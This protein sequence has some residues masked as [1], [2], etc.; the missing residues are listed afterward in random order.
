MMADK[1]VLFTTQYGEVGKER[2]PSAAGYLPYFEEVPNFYDFFYVPTP[3]FSLR[4]LREGIDYPIDILE[5]PTREEYRDALER[6]YDVVGFSFYTFAV[7][8][9]F[10]MAELARD[11]GV[12]EVWAGGYGVDTPAELEKHFD[13][14]FRGHGEDE[15]SRILTG[16]PSDGKKH[17]V[18][19]VRA[20]VAKREIPVG[21]LMTSM[22]CGAGCKF[23]HAT[24][25]MP[26][27]T[28]VPLEEIRRTLDEYANR[29]IVGVIIFDDD[30]DVH[31]D[32]SQKTIDMLCER[33]IAWWCMARADEIQG[34]VGELKEKGMFGICVGI[35]S[36]HESD[37]VDCRKKETVRQVLE[38]IE[39]L[40]DNDMWFMTTYM[41]GWEHDTPGSIDEDIRIIAKM[42]VP[43]FQTMILTPYPGTIIWREM[44]EQGR[45]TDWDWS[46][47][48]HQYLVFD[49]PHLTT[50][51]ATEALNKCY[52]LF[53]WDK[54]LMTLE[55]WERS[56]GEGS[57]L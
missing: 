15:V 16:R 32:H 19:D 1:K 39:E 13:R 18:M 7:D 51:D 49:H 48:T 45:I 23:C 25:Y 47:Y 20:T 31:S 11:S 30:F 42:E 17:P 28:L 10:E 35:E 12:K 38:V 2:F 54:V 26:K 24:T 40:K 6:G 27:R 33:G 44:L 50:A 52:D 21:Y 41:F 43:F 57:F 36:L 46:H 8:E 37:L 53:T 34:R 9:V 5:Y 14:V 4:F 22:G 29:G 56:F 55:T 3:A